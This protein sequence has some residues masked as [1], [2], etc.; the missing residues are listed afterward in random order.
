MFEE[1]LLILMKCGNTCIPV[2]L[3]YCDVLYSSDSDVKTLPIGIN[4][5]MVPYLDAFKIHWDLVN[6]LQF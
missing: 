1:A 4:N 2:I 6:F 3:L 5:A